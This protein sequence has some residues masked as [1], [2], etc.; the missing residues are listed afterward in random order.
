MKVTQVAVQLYTIRDHLKTPG[1]MAR[2]FR[3]LRAIGFRAIELGGLGPISDKELKALLDGEG[4]AC[5]ASH[6]PA[7]QLI[8]NP[9]HIAAKLK[10]IGCPTA[11]YPYPSGISFS[12]PEEL[13][14]FTRHLNEAGSRLRDAGI[15]FAYHNHNIEFRKIE[16]TLALS[17][18]F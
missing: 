10:T 18:I 15:A 12:T 17:K 14:A 6:E 13:S 16:G 1:E 8:E 3:R 11:V 4:L 7:R 2:S 5:C 9:E